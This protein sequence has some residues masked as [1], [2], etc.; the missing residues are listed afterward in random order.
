MNTTTT[1]ARRFVLI[2]FV[3][4][5]TLAGITACKNSDQDASKPASAEH[6]AKSEHPQSEHP[7]EHPK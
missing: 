4:L 7:T 2:G 1:P 5:I 3:A 6:P